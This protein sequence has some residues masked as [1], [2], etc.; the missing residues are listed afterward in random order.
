MVL[1]ACVR[2]SHVFRWR[3]AAA[4]RTAAAAALSAIV[5]VNLCLDTTNDTTAAIAAA[6]SAGAVPL[7]EAAVHTHPSNPI[8]Q[9]WGP[10][11]LTKLKA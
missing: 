5:L 4:V 1:A 9:K 8:L 3:A 11:L 7:V 10:K 6:V 2:H